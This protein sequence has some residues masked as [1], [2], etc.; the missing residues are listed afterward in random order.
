MMYGPICLNVDIAD[1]V[2]HRVCIGGSYCI[3]LPPLSSSL[4]IRA[5]FGWHA[6]A[7]KNKTGESELPVWPLPA[8]QIWLWRFFVGRFPFIPLPSFL[9]RS[10]YLQ[11]SLGLSLDFEPHSVLMRTFFK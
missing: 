4:V 7:L 1:V 9:F 10:R 5:L 8:G 11:S 2:L 3:Y 6:R